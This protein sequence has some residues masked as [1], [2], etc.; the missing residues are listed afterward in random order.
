MTSHA[1]VAAALAHTSLCNGQHVR[2]RVD[3][4]SMRP[5][6]D[7]GDYVWVAQVAVAALR[8]GDVVTVWQ[9]NGLL[10]HRLLRVDEH[11]CVTKGDNCVA[12]DPPLDHKFIMGRVVAAE[13]RGKRIDLQ[14][15]RW[16]G[17]GKAVAWVGGGVAT[18]A[19]HPLRI[20]RGG[21]LM[22]RAAIWSLLHITLMME[23]R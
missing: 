17:V 21:S 8:P 13:R 12:P 9:H 6:V 7:V 20:V 1:T 15:R 18:F 2:V 3:G 5:L 23:E 4:T 16:L 22:F 14:R 11:T 10:T 19:H